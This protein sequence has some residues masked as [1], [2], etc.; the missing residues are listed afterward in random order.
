MALTQTVQQ[1][2]QQVAGMQSHAQMSEMA[3]HFGG[4]QDL[5][6]LVNEVHQ[7]GRAGLS[8]DEAYSITKVRYPEVFGRGD[9]IQQGGPAG[10]TEPPSRNPDLSRQMP[11]EEAETKQAMYDRLA[12]ARTSSER[13]QAGQALIKGRIFR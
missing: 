1:M 4:D 7:D 8:F 9:P 11:D 6:N 10:Y 12:G 3:Q 13:K 5:A 2:Q